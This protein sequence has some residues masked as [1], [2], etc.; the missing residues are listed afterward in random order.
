MDLG[1]QFLLAIVAGLMAFVIT[2]VTGFDLQKLLTNVGACTVMA[3][4]TFFM[5]QAALAPEQADRVSTDMIQWFGDNLRAILIDDI[6][7]AF[8]GVILGAVKR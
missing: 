4:M 2:R 8:V 5:F 1:S 6:A 3:P 7:G